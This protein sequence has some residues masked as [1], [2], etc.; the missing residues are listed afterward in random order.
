MALYFERILLTGFNVIYSTLFILLFIYTSTFVFL[1][2]SFFLQMYVH[3][4]ICIYLFIRISIIYFFR[5]LFH[6]K[7]KMLCWSI[8]MVSHQQLLVTPYQRRV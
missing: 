1:L 6:I 4:N 2:Y 5:K 3:T 7:T 8:F